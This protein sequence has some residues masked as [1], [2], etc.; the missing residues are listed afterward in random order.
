MVAGLLLVRPQ[1]LH[2]S[3]HAHTERHE[4]A[5]EPD[6]E[7]GT[8]CFLLVAYTC[9]TG[10]HVMLGRRRRTERSQPYKLA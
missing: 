10:Q 2:D 1:L 9:R 7:Y 4:P 3:H 5:Y 8:E 6:E